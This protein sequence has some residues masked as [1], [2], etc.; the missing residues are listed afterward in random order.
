MVLLVLGLAVLLIPLGT[1]LSFGQAA[2]VTAL[3]GAAA[4]TAWAA[5]RESGPLALILEIGGIEYCF[6]ALPED[7][8][9]VVILEF[10]T[11]GGVPRVVRG[12]E[13]PT[14]F[15][16]ASYTE[17][18]VEPAGRPRLELHRRRPGARRGRLVLTRGRTT[19]WDVA[20][21]RVG[22]PVPMSD[23]AVRVLGLAGPVT[24]VFL[25]R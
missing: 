12:D 6:P 4:R 13:T 1:A 14:G 18:P 5:W 11:E 24:L 2:V 21:L 16:G 9:G 25:D 23:I 8:K 17:L 7:E 20:D 3:L 15:G 22:R 10:E 19:L